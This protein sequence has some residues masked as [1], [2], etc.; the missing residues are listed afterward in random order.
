LLVDAEQGLGDTLQ[1]ARYVPL[2]LRQG[3]QV[4]LRTHPMLH[5][6]LATL[7]GA[8]QLASDRVPAPPHDLRCPVMSLPLALGTSLQTIPAAVPYLSADPAAAAEW[9]RRLGPAGRARIGV[10]W[11]GRQHRPVNHG[12]DMPL[13]ALQPLLDLPADFISLQK[14]IPGPDRATLASLEGRLASLGEGLTDFADTAALLENIDLL[15]AVDTSVVHL[16]GALGR[17]V[18]VMNRHASCWRWLEGRADS[19]W[20]PSARLFRQSTPGCWD[21]VVAE[22]R[23]AAAAWLLEDAPRPPPP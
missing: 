7:P 21:A 23:R 19:P 5:A 6:V 16:A 3:G 12:R 8:P 1:F 4:V 13:A 17:P 11:A 2:V 15:I 20:Y 14:D 22:V 9:D 18:W 10:V